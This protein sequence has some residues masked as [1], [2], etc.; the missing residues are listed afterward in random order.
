MELAV[1]LVVAGALLGGAWYVPAVTGAVLLLLGCLRRKGRS[2]PAWTAVVI[3]QRQ[4]SQEAT[5]T[6]ATACTTGVGRSAAA[7][8]P[9][10]GPPA[11]PPSADGR[12][13]GATPDPLQPLPTLAPALGP[14]PHGDTTIGMVSDGTRLTAVLQV[15]AADETPGLRA[16][17]HALRTAGGAPFPLG[18]L[19]GA[20]HTDGIPLASVQ[21]V[22]QVRP[23]VTPQLPSDSVARL[24]YAPHG[25][26][27]A[28]P[29]LR[30]T[31]IALRLDPEL[32]P[33]AIA[34]RGAAASGAQRCLSHATR[35]L[36]TR[37]AAVGLRP[38]P[39]SQRGLHAALATAACAPGRSEDTPTPC[40]ESA[41]AVH[42]AGL[43][44]CSHTVDRIPAQLTPLLP[45]ATDANAYATT[46][47]LTV[48]SSAHRDA[49]RIDA[50]VRTTAC[51]SDALHRA[52]H[53]LE[54]ACRAAHVPLTRL[55]RQQL[56]G[57]L[58]TLPLGGAT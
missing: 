48:R 43:W 13:A 10:S 46:L 9:P 34:A 3:A 52:R 16:R 14:A 21:L 7:S 33:E 36:T 11:S 25:T 29:A 56:P 39:L 4:R 17:G 32:C 1:A 45:A 15:E 37:L 57:L 26:S 23:A 30:L 38:T 12:P 19:V 54:R 55:D 51:S 41:Y 49:L 22:Q 44:H 40:A 31:W 58:A 5:A 28:A 6:L 42:H 35:L 18:L 50:R 20:L 2:L 53:D 8:H 27:A 24:A 47:S